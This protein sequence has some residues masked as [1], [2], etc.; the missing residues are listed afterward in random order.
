M[1]GG[2]DIR[3]KCLIYTD[4]RACTLVFV[5]AKWSNKPC[6]V[7]LFCWQIFAWIRFLSNRNRKKQLTW[8]TWLG[9]WS[10]QYFMDYVLH[11]WQFFIFISSLF[12]CN[13]LIDCSSNQITNHLNI[14]GW[15]DDTADKSYHSFICI[16]LTWF[17]FRRNGRQFI[18]LI[19]RYLSPLV[20][21]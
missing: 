7:L 8:M 20:Y 3:P 16:E 6:S 19:Y 9:H 5:S 12:P 13:Q 4:K 1:L 21:F 18:S 11:L 10:W 2:S 17:I 15:M 14:S